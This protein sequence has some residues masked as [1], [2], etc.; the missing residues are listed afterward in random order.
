MHWEIHNG[1]RVAAGE[2]GEPSDARGVFETVLLRDGEPMFLEEHLRR[3]GEGCAH[4]GLRSAPPA[5][6]LR[7]AA[8]ELMEANGVPTGVLRWA[9]WGG[10]GGAG[11]SLRV[12]PPR[13]ASLKA[14]W[15]VEI[16][17][18]RLPPAGPDSRCK[19]LGRRLWGEA[20]AVGR[21]AGCDEVLL[22]D[23]GGRLVEG[24]VSNVFCAQEGRLVTP[25]LDCGPLPGIV[26]AKVLELAAQVGLP[27]AEGVLT[28]E[29]LAATEEAFVTNSL[30]G[31][32]P[33]GSI[34]GR[35]LSA[36][37]PATLLLQ[38]AWTDLYG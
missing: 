11:W 1:R 12:D 10:A 27:V 5:A 30:A 32:K 7:R 21:A 35:I 20:L 24:A 8:R 34:N 28:A 3:Y 18:T 22:C 33:L 14:R 9:A 19:H 23:E 6:E 25:S 37:G 31:L 17:P 16:S 29:D 36:P 4:F 26:R 15:R 38:E 13:P 2:G